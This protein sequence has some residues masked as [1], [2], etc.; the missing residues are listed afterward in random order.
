MAPDLKSRKYLQ[1]LKLSI[2]IILRFFNYLRFFAYRREELMQIDTHDVE[3]KRE[4][5]EIRIP[6]TK[7]KQPRNFTITQG[8]IENMDLLEILL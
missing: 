8:S 2:L 6:K 1:T 5:I 7:T 3:D 4:F